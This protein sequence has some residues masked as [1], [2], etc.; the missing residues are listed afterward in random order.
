MRMTCLAVLA[1]LAVSP[2]LGQ[3][4]ENDN[5]P[6]PPLTVSFFNLQ[7]CPAGWAAA[8][9]VD[10]RTIVPVTGSAGIGWKVGNALAPREDRTHRHDFSA[11]INL[12]SVSYIAIA[13]CCNNTLAQAGDFSFSATTDAASAN[14]P[15]VQLLACVKQAPAGTTTRVPDDVLTFYGAVDCPDAW[16]QAVGLQGRFLTGV[17]E[18]GEV[19]A[20]GGD[21]LAAGETRTHTHA[22]SGNVDTV[23]Q[24]VAVGS[25]C[26]ASGYGANGVFAY[27]GTTA[28]AAADMPYIQYLPCTP[29]EEDDVRPAPQ[30]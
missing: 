9:N 29:V 17:P 19:G 5:D 22:F 20:F 7:Q 28:A 21:P 27:A 16:G 15:Y 25:G 3:G 30:R 11:S 14:I 10:G 12:Y 1:M 8:T 24:T 13:G 26:C 6:Y 2:M 4:R 23:A 18:G